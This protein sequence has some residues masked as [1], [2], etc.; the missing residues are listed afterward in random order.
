[1]RSWANLMHWSSSR[2]LG[3][4]NVA[5]SRDFATCSWINSA[6]GLNLVKNS[7]NFGSNFFNTCVH[8][9]LRSLIFQERFSKL[10]GIFSRIKHRLSPTSWWAPSSTNFLNALLNYLNGPLCFFEIL[11]R[12][13]RVGC[14]HKCSD[15]KNDMKI[16]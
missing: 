9:P 1:M 16:R 13:F 2:W 7:K 11:I 14:G 4:L 10:S 8:L 12:N 6:L 15:S 3:S 5:D